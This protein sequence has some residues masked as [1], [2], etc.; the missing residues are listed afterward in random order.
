MSD[1]TNLEQAPKHNLPNWKECALRVG[2][3]KYLADKGA[4][5]DGKIVDDFY[6]DALLPEQI[7]AFIY[8]YDDSDEYK[9]SWFLHRL[10]LL[11]NE[12]KQQ[13]IADAQKLI[14]GHVK[15][16]SQV[17]KQNREQADE[18]TRLTLLVS[19]YEAAIDEHKATVSDYADHAIPLEP[20]NDFDLKLWQTREK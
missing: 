7:H 14:D 15:Y 2:N 10:E 11:L 12:T 18:I 16:I 13:S 3:Q 4:I 8:E 6:Y 17:G 1:I 9:S 5:K 19:K 20:M